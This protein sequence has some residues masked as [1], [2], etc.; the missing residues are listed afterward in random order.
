MDP[1][2]S[3]DIDWLIT[4][5]DQFTPVQLD[6]WLGHLGITEDEFNHR[7]LATERGVRFAVTIACLIGMAIVYVVLGTLTK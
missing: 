4:H 1:R 7:L 5:L 6:Y 3:A 2:K